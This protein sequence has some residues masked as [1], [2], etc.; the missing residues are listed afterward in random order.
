M[1][2]IP[3]GVIGLGRVA[4]LH[5][6]PNLAG[7]PRAEIAGLCDLSHD[8]TTR[9]ADSYGLPR[10]VVATDT[11]ELMARDLAAIVIANRHHGPLVRQ[12]LDAGLHVLVEKPVCWGID[13]GTAL[14]DLEGRTRPAVV[15]YMKRYDPAVCRLLAAEATA[16]PVLVRLHLFAGGRHRYEKLHRRV[17]A[18]DDASADAEDRAIAG[19]VAAT[20]GP[21]HAHRAADVRMLA[22]FAIHDLNLVRAL[23]GPLAVESSRRF[24]TPCGPGFLVMMN[25]RGTPV[26]AEIVADFQTARDWDETLTVFYPGGAT[27]L[28]FGSPFLRNAPTVTREHLA[29]GTDIV[30]RKMIVSYDSAYRLELEHLLDCASGTVRSRTP[31]AEAVA[32]LQLAYDIARMAREL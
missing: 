14:A 30:S 12:A 6:L 3:V 19:L 18:A 25:A 20:L 8:L 26:S 27:E 16:P 9:L 2:R 32:D 11:G 10:S 15:G 29:D 5:H 31:I 28:R 22:E 4:Q 7:S 13:E 23:L 1:R 24:A 17:A 21:Q